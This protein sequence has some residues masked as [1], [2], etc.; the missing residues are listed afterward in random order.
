MWSTSHPGW[1]QKLLIENSRFDS[2]TYERPSKA[3]KTSETLSKFLHKRHRFCFCRKVFSLTHPNRPTTF[4]TRTHDS[5]TQRW[6]KFALMRESPVAVL[7]FHVGSL[8]ASLAAPRNSPNC[9]V[10]VED[11]GSIRCPKLWLFGILEMFGLFW[12]GSISWRFFG[13]HIC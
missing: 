12:L 7:W 10:G 5:S 4:P 2:K 8:L 6:I 3:T 13:G 9:V 1:L 11:T